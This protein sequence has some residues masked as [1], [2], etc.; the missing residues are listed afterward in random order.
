MNY[1][2]NFNKHW[3]SSIYITSDVMAAFYNQKT[4]LSEYYIPINASKRQRPPGA[5]CFK[6]F[7]P[8]IGKEKEKYLRIVLGGIFARPTK[9]L[10]PTLNF[11][12]FYLFA[13]SSIFFKIITRFQIKNAHSSSERC[14]RTTYVFEFE[15]L[16]RGTSLNCHLFR[17]VP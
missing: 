6:Q 5:D 1:Q 9:L 17:S 2:Y 4:G 15:K 16:V 12:S 13:I 10:N 11:P 7:D 8:W 3:L 14:N